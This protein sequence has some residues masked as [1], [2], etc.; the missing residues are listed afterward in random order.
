MTSLDSF[1]GVRIIVL[2]IWV[3]ATWGYLHRSHH[4]VHFR[5]DMLSIEQRSFEKQSNI[6]FG[7]ME[8]SPLGLLEFNPSAEVIGNWMDFFGAR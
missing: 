2:I 7:W 1:D 3:G 6:V 4:A 8:P 5:L